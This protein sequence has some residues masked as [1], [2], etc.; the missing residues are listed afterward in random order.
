VVTAAKPQNEGSEGSRGVRVVIAD[1]DLLV[2]E[3]VAS[4]L[5]RNG[6]E[7][8]GQAGDGDHLLTLVRMQ[9]PDLAIV[10]IRMPPTHTTEGLEAARTIRAELPDVA[11]LVLSAYV[12]INHAMEL[13]RSGERSGYLLKRR[14]TD[15]D[16]F[17]DTLQRLVRGGSVVDPT[18]ISELVD[19][20]RIDDPLE[21]LSQRER[22]VLALMAQGRSNGGIARRLW[23]SERTVEKHVQ[24]IL[25]KL[26]LPETTDDHRRVLAVVTFLKAG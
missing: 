4:L 20:R 2:R 6:Y 22:E 3:G 19:A 14:V 8:V 15:M 25:A 7:V 26:G 16:E 1:D 21:E 9:K 13:L 23:I 11:I 10:D 5:H 12:D 17:V 18:L 24:S